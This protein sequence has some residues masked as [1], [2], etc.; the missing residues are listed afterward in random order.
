MSCKSRWHSLQSTFHQDVGSLP[1]GGGVGGARNDGGDGGTG[2]ATGEAMG[3]VTG[4]GVASRGRVTF[5]G[6]DSEEDR[7]RGLQVGELGEGSRRG[8]R[9]VGGDGEGVVGVDA[10]EE[11]C[12]SLSSGPPPSNSTSQCHLTAFLVC[13]AGGGEAE[14]DSATDGASGEGGESN[15]GGWC[16][17]QWERVARHV[18]GSRKWH[19]GVHCFKGGHVAVTA[20]ETMAA[21]SSGSQRSKGGQ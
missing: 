2:W 14:G 8:V 10:R 7:G 21:F 11:S 1:I 5:V 4:I 20:Q 16:Q 19:I 13:L 17:I 6:V 12:S 15:R 18:P 9:G 3:R